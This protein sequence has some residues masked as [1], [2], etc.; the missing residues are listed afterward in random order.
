MK[1]LAQVFLAMAEAGIR[2]QTGDDPA[3]QVRH[4]AVVEG[5]QAMQSEHAA[6]GPISQ[7]PEQAKA[8]ITD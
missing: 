2:L 6:A 5:R 7:G 4:P 1:N 3:V 8:S